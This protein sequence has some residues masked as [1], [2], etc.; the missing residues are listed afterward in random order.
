MRERIGGGDRPDVFASANMAHPQALAAAG[1]GGPVVLFARNRLCVL[2]QPGVAVTSA[3]LLD[4][5]LDPAVRVGM[6]TPGADPS[7]DYA[8]DLFERA[9][10]LRPGALA[11]LDEKALQLTGG[12]DSPK[13]PAGR[14]NYAWV[15]DEGRADLFLTYCTNARLARA[16]SPSLQEIAIP[17]DLAV[18]AD[19]GLIVLA[20]ERPE[21]W[22]LAAF[23][24]AP[25]GQGILQSYG[26]SVGG[27]PAEGGAE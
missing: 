25:E 13:P 27:L 3:T 23:V 19:Y 6:S 1:L 15:M 21:A 24:L 12:P 16:E 20:P 11:A 8:W 17:E 7:G 18:G 4:V 9:E 5:L 14:N 2:A 26:F 22:R 10:A